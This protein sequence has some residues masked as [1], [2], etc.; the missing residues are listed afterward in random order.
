MAAEIERNPEDV[1]EDLI[2]L[3]LRGEQRDVDACSKLFDMYDHGTSAVR[4][5]H[6]EAIRWYTVCAENDDVAA[7]NTIGFM[8]LMGKGIRKNREKAVLWLQKAAQNGSA[9]AMYHMGQMYDQGLCD[10]EPDLGKAVDWF[11]RA[12][13]AGDMDARFSMGCICSTPRTKYTDGRKAVSCRITD[14]TRSFE[15]AELPSVLPPT[16]FVVTELAY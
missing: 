14:A 3:R 10:T 16:S 12:A 11:T 15:E 13:D 6:A 5:D 1:M 8:Y 4:K 9:E 7:Q 2:R